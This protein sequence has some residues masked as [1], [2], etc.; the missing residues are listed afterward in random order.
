MTNKNSV[1]NDE[2]LYRRIKDN[3]DHIQRH[4]RDE[5]KKL[6]INRDCFFDSSFQP[7][8]FRAEL[9][10]FNPLLCRVCVTDRHGVVGFTAG[11]VRSIEIEGYK[12]KVL[13]KP[14]DTANCE[15]NSAEYFRNIA[16]AIICVT[17]IDDDAPITEKHAFYELLDILSDISKPRDWILSPYA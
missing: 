11:K 7:S 12:V 5:Q 3:E 9:M 10:N 16:H 8:V 4:S 2:L 1:R 15:H 14:E 13:A 17:R 6:E